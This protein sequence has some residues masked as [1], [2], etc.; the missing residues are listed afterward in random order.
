ML[1]RLERSIFLAKTKS[2]QSELTQ[3]DS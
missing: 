1:V 3:L 2:F